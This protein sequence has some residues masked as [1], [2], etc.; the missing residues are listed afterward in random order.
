MKTPGTAPKPTLVERWT[1]LLGNVA[2]SKTAHGVLGEL[3]ALER[4]SLPARIPIEV[5]VEFA[6]HDIETDTRSYEVKST[7]KRYD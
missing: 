3:L 1:G 2:S 4:F 6:S 5:W 7:L